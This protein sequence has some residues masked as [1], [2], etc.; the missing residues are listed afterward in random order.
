[1]IGAP[2]NSNWM[3]GT[4]SFLWRRLAFNWPRNSPSFMKIE[5]IK[6][7][8]SRS[9]LI[10]YS[11][12][13]PLIPPDGLFPWIFPIKYYILFSF[14]VL[15]YVPRPS[16]S[17]LFYHVVCGEVSKLWKL[18][19]LVV[20]FIT[21]VAVRRGHIILQIGSVSVLSETVGSYL[22]SWLLGSLNNLCTLTAST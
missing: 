5:I 6:P 20:E 19:L 16:H 8:F 17:F 1:M 21:C 7:Y 13:L 3:F 12:V 4:V 11:S 2:W 14:T 15:C 18:A 22:L 9:I 10:L